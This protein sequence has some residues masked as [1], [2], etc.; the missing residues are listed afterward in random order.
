MYTKLYDIYVNNCI[1]IFTHALICICD[2]LGNTSLFQTRTAIATPLQVYIFAPPSGW[3]VR[4]LTGGVCLMGGVRPGCVVLLCDFWVMYALVG[5][6]SFWVVYA[7]VGGVRLDGC[8]PFWRMV[9]WA[10]A[11]QTSSGKGERLLG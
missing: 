7:L 8:A 2:L 6:A 3:W 11:F 9:V 10:S 4:L 5:C 1:S